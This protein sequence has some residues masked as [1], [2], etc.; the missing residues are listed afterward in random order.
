MKVSLS[1]KYLCDNLLRKKYKM[2]LT[3][4]LHD[5]DY[6]SCFACDCFEKMLE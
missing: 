3:R 1:Q 4:I 5:S 2:L 6:A